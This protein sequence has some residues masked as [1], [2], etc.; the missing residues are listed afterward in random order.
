MNECLSKS[1]QINI[2]C[3]GEYRTI[4]NRFSYWHILFIW[5]DKKLLQD[6]GGKSSQKGKLKANL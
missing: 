1:V 2:T 6:Y 3:N 5:F 4:D